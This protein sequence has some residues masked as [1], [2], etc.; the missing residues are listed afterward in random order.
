MAKRKTRFWLP[1]RMIDIGMI[2]ALNL[3]D[4]RVLL[5]Y[6]CD[7]SDDLAAIKTDDVATIAGVNSRSVQRSIQTLTRERTIKRLSANKGGRGVL[8]EYQLFPDPNF[9]YGSGGRFWIPVWFVNSD[10]FRTLGLAEIRVVL[11]YTRLANSDGEIY[12]SIDKVANMANL[13]SRSVQRA[14]RRVCSLGLLQRVSRGLGGHKR[15][16]TYRLLFRAW[17]DYQDGPIVDQTGKGYVPDPWPKGDKGTGV[18]KSGLSTK[19]DKGT[20]VSNPK[21]RQSG[22]KTTTNDVVNHDRAVSPEGTPK[23]SLRG[24]P[25]IDSKVAG[26]HRAAAFRTG[27]PGDGDDQEVSGTAG[28]L[29]AAFR[30]IDRGAAFGGPAMN[31]HNTR[32]EANRQIRALDKHLERVP[33]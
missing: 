14:L 15:P 23:E 32:R 11:I 24:S 16:T 10:L 13:S 20:G 19:G 28:G 12:W 2:N 1:D 27:R 33:K 17:L 21:G 25:S 8:T 22:S 9:E 4:T 31:E 30:M 29:V 26:R 3:T 18:S 7:A 5:V 6:A